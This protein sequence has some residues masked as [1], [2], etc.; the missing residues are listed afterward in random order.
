MKIFI[1]ILMIC[2]ILVAYF[3]GWNLGIASERNHEGFNTLKFDGGCF[4]KANEITTLRS[5]SSGRMITYAIIRGNL[6]NCGRQD[7]IEIRVNNQEEFS[8]MIKTYFGIEESQ[9]ITSMLPN[10]ARWLVSDIQG[11]NRVIFSPENG[12]AFSEMKQTG[13][14][15]P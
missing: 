7:F 5:L 3:S 1:G 10:T 12:V 6:E 14:V 15:S 8:D 13:K 2:A 11:G 9:V 4:V